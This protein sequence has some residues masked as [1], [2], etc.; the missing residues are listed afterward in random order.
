V[1][2]RAIFTMADQ[3]KVVL[4]WSIKRRHFQWPWKTPIPARGLS[5]TA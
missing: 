2:D 4:L 5:A 3:Q 1:Q